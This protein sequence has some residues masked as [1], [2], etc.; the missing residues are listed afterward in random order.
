MRLSQVASVCKEFG[1][2]NV[3]FN[4][5]SLHHYVHLIFE[6]YETVLRNRNWSYLGK[7]LHQEGTADMHLRTRF[8]KEVEKCEHLFFRAKELRQ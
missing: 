4:P 7:S 5:F 1:I 2:I 3:T 8:S 6:R